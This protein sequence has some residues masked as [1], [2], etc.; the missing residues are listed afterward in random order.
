MSKMHGRRLPAF[1]PTHADPRL[2]AELFGELV[3]HL[4]EL[5]DRPIEEL[6]RAAGMTPADWEQVE[7][8]H[9]PQAVEQLVWMAAALHVGDKLLAHMLS[10]CARAAEEQ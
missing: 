1:R 2:C 6:A 10:L 4:R 5:E 3:R 9:A 7:G 8:G